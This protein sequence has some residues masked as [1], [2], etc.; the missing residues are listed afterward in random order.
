MSEKLLYEIEMAFLKQIYEHKGAIGVN[1]LLHVFQSSYGLKEDMFNRI[2]GVVMQKEYCIIEKIRKLDNTEE[3]VIFVTYKGLGK[4]LEKKKFSVKNLLKNKIAYELKCEGYK[5]YSDWLDANR[6]QLALEAEIT[7]MFAR[8]LADMRIILMR[9]AIAVRKLISGF[10]KLIYPDGE[11]SKDEVAEI[12]DISLELRRRVK[13]QLKKIGGMEFYDVNFSY[14]DNDSF[15]EHF[16]TVPEQG[17]GKMIPEG[18]GKPGCLY[19]VSKSKTGMIGCYRLETQMMPGNGKLTCTGIGSGKEPK[20]AT[21]TAFNYLKA[22]GNAISGSISTTTKDYIINYQDMQGL[23][24]TGNLAL[25]T[26]IAISSAALSKPPISS[27]AVLGEI[28]IGGTL[29]KVEDLAST[30]QVC[31]DSGAKKVLLPITSAADLGTVPSDLVGAFS[32]IFYSSPE[33]A[34]YKAL[35]VE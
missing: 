25:P 24:M 13:E 2:L 17:G 21:N 22:N 30:L 8:V 29:I 5:T 11:V 31:L 3:E 19:T 1:E 28:S 15:D 26:L 18:M 7:R 16:V 4:F 20:E 34:V 14:I 32:L 6:N 33:E 27:L 12:M 23:G 35:G 9:D 10:I